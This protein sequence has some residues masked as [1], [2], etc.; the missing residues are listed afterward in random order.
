MRLVRAP[1]DAACRAAFRRQPSRQPNPEALRRPRVRLVVVTCLPVADEVVDYYLGLIPAAED[2]RARL[3]LL[4]PEDDSPRPLAQKI[5]ERPE[6]LAR[7][8][9]LM[10]DRRDAFIVVGRFGIDFVVARCDGGWVPNA[11]EINLR[12]GGTSHPYG[13]LWLLTDGSLDED[14]TTFRTPSGQAKYYFAIDEPLASWPGV[15]SAAPSEKQEQPAVDRRQCSISRIAAGSREILLEREAVDVQ[16]SIGDDP[17]NVASRSSCFRRP[18]PN[19]SRASGP[20]CRGRRGVLQRPL[21]LRH[22]LR[23]TRLCCPRA[24]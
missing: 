14:K 22:A 9:E 16:C 18:A 7:L 1:T 15:A 19:H 5:L 4:S 21:R 20:R 10:P 2:A 13:A 8:R 3:H 24:R 11:V 6:L 17:V 12:E 23:D